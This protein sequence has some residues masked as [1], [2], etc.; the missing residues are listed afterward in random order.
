MLPYHPPEGIAFDDVRELDVT[1]SH[2]QWREESEAG[3]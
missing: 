3:W 1:A 2:G